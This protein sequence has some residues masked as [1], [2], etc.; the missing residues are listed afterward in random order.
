MLSY[1]LNTPVLAEEVERKMC[2]KQ[3]AVEHSCRSSLVRLG[4]AHILLLPDLK[5][6]S[7]FINQWAG[8]WEVLGITGSGLRVKDPFFHQVISRGSP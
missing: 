3:A 7:Y 1:V 8:L 4:R 2:V 6:R 5:Q